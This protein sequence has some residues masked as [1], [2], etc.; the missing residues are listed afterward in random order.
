MAIEL[1]G[2]V[3]SFLSLVGAGRPNANDD[4]VR[5]F[6][7]HMRDFATPVDT[8]HQ[9]ATGTAKQLGGL[10]TKSAGVHFQ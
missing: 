6:A 10:Q 4:K 1:P 2:P 9:Q 3:V 8:T 5:D 7:A